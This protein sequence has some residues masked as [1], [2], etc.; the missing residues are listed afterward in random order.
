MDITFSL[1]KSKDVI[2]TYD[3]RRLGKIIDV[4]FDKTTGK[5]L[6]FIVPGMKKIFKKSEDIFI[7]LN[8]ITRIG[9]DV[10]LVSLTPVTEN[11]I[12]NNFN[13]EK[14]RVLKTY[15]RYKKVNKK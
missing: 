2:N 7:P 11:L 13:E 1:L 6:G 15:A 3:G 12:N 8:L 9:D 4:Y 10:I 14:S 5:V